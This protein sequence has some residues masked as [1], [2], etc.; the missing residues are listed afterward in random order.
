MCGEIYPNTKLAILPIDVL[1]NIF[2]YTYLCQP[3]PLLDDIIHFTMSKK[4]I[5]NCYNTT[6]WK[7]YNT[8]WLEEV[9]MLPFEMDVM[10]LFFDD[11]YQ[12]SKLY[13]F[14]NPSYDNYLY[15]V[16]MRNRLLS[17][18]QKVDRYLEHFIHRKIAS[19]INI[20]WGLM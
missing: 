14:T 5:L 1:M 10:R 16:F 12:Y 7:H 20:L 2:S 9:N 4:F 11:I 13:S 8:V 19:K 18:K 6:W 3:K 15:S 17:T